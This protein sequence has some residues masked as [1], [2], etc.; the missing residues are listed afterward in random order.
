MVPDQ[1]A[2]CTGDESILIQKTIDD[3]Q[4]SIGIKNMYNKIHKE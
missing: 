3:Y 4:Y 1:I 2:W